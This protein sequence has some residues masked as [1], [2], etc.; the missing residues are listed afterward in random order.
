LCA[1]VGGTIVQEFWRGA[2]V[3][4]RSTGTDFF[5][6]IVGLVG[7]NKRRYGGYI[8]HIGVILFF[9]GCAGQGYKQDVK[10][11]LKPGEEAKIGEFTVRHNSIA[12]RDDGQKQMVTAT[13]SVF[14]G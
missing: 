8:V 4:R 2:N 14:K 5:T 7:R 9:L 1:Y 13:M 3:R 11:L 10:T 12:V 6:A